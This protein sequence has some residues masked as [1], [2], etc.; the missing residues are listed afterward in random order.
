MTCDVLPPPHLGLDVIE[1]Q[2]AP[3]QLHDHLLGPQPTL[4]VQPLQ[5]GY[6]VVQRLQLPAIQ[7]AGE[8]VLQTANEGGARWGSEWGVSRGGGGGVLRVPPTSTLTYTVSEFLLSIS[9]YS[10]LCTGTHRVSIY[11]NRCDR[12]ANIIKCFVG[13]R[14][15]Y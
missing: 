7:L 12:E 4:R 1:H 9:E 15:E 11:S 10:L 2:V 8:Q 14:T 3:L 13:Q 5:L 6:A